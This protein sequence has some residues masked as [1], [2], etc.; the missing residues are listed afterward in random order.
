MFG[1]LHRLSEFAGFKVTE[2][3]YKNH[4]NQFSERYRHV[5][6][7]T[8]QA[9]EGLSD[10]DLTVQSADFASPGKWHLAHTT[11]FFEQFLLVAHESAY[12]VFDENFAY[13]FNSY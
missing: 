6:L 11:W 9:V 3:E 2:S 13:L 4:M 10:A 12:R 5:R 1:Q 8:M 7:A